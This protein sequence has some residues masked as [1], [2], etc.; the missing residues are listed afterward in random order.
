[1]K[2][3][4]TVIHSATAVNEGTVTPDSWIA[5]AGGTVTAIGTGSSWPRDAAEVIDASGRL[6]L[7]GVIDTHVH[8]R[9]PGMTRKGDF[10]SESLAAAA[11]GVT[12]VIDMPNTIPATVT[13][14]AWE[15]KM[16][17]ARRKSA[18][19]YAFFL[20]ATNSNL[21]TLLEAD[22]S[23]IAGIKLFLG[24]STGDMLVDSRPVIARLFEAAPALIAVH[25]E[26]EDLIRRG[27]ERVKSLYGENPVPIAC[28]P[29]IRSREACAESASL[30][31][32]MA[33]RHRARL[34][35][36]HVST[37]D[38][39]KLLSDPELRGLVTAE[40]CPHY[41][42]F[43]SSEYPR[44]G[45]RIK[46]NPAI[47]DRA[48]RDA[49][50]E[51]LASGVIDTVATDHA[52]HLPADKEGD[53]LHAASGMPGIEMSLPVMLE[54]ADLGIIPLARVAEVMA[55]RPA[56]IFRIERRG[57]LR[58]GYAA[59]LVLA[60]RTGTPGPVSDTDMHSLCGWTPYAGATFHWRVSETRVNGIRVY[61][62]ITPRLVPGAAQPLRFGR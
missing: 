58:P 51:A 34:H 28:H 26:S 4:L 56:D 45:S 5:F 54:L 21:D 46:C 11:G 53:A 20:G 57:Y 49:L 39:L 32:D 60:G 30:A 31:I 40:T 55:H 23:R 44:L 18:V 1:M 14:K 48:D 6:L 3:N 37:A 61:D 7:P 15:D 9:D 16:N 59:D 43:D 22:Y 17:V 41:L 62:G 8:F 27:R 50:R 10:A 29:Q 52:P 2:N 25:A 33:R 24:S 42:W 47:K 12:S 19:N 36:L 38:E 13:L 35:L